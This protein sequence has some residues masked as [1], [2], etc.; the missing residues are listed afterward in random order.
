[1][2]LITSARKRPRMGQE[3]HLFDTYAFGT[4]YASGALGAPRAITAGLA[5]LPVMDTKTGPKNPA[6][7]PQQL[8]EQVLSLSALCPPAGECTNDLRPA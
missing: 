6:D 8:I 1:M 7:H 2:L 5:H 3:S 4:G